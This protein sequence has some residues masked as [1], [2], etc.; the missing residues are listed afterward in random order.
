MRLYKAQVL[1]FIESRT[2][3]LHHAAPTVLDV[4]DRVQRRFLREIGIS[5]SHALIHYRLAPLPVRRDIAM[6]GL[7]HRVCHDSAPAA[8]ADLFPRV[9]L[10]QGR[11]TRGLSARHALQLADFVDI[12]GH[13]DVLKRSCF[14]LVTI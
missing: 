8:L 14:G 4:I 10:Q 1:S 5:E 11:I 3:A 9:P 7:L 2:P 6:L 13:T 12:G